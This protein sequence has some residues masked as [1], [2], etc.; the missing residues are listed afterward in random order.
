MG[1]TKQD[2]LEAAKIMLDIKDNESDSLLSIL[3]DETIDAILAYCHIDI[4]PRQLVSFV[5]TVVAK[6]YTSVKGGSIKA[7]T[8]GERRV[9][10]T[11][12]KYDFLTDFA[13][14]LRPFVS[15]EAWLPSQ[16]EDKNNE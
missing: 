5:P 2:M 3:I 10:Y 1:D 8:E 14:R 7:L 6:R 4:M 11:D 9:E 13:K 15:R 16:V 12:G